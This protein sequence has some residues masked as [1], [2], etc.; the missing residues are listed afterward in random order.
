[1][2]EGDTKKAKY[3]SVRIWTEE[4]SEL[5]EVMLLKA[6]KEK[7]RITEVAFVSEAVSAKCKKEKRKLGI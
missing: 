3:E 7:R 6:L 5:E 2:A 4:K 1:M